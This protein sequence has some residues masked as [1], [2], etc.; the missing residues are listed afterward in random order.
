MVPG[1]NNGIWTQKRYSSAL[2]R[3]VRYWG[4]FSRTLFF[5]TKAGAAWIMGWFMPWSL[6]IN[7]WVV[8]CMVKS[9]TLWGSGWGC[10]RLLWW[11]SVPPRGSCLLRWC[12]WLTPPSLPPLHRPEL[13]SH[14]G[15][16][17]QEK[18]EMRWACLGLRDATLLSSILL[19]FSSHSKKNT[20]NLGAQTCW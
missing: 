12:G 10:L 2:Y 3:W 11:C 18:T 17:G 1:W 5:R 14:R 16:A 20:G 19:S 6:E 15:S 4:K 8:L 13:L 7:W 9:L